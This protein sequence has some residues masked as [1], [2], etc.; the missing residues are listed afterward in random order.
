MRHNGHIGLGPKNLD[1]IRQIC[2]WKFECAQLR[3]M[4]TMHILHKFFGPF[5]ANKLQEFNY[6]YANHLQHENSRICYV[7]CH[8]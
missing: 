7:Y 3:R 6:Q 1:Q 2:M 4:Y 8:I 5:N